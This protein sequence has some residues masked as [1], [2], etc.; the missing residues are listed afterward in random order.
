MSRRTRAGSEPLRCSFCHK[1]EPA[2]GKLISSPNDY[3]RVYICDECIAVCKRILEDDG[4]E[5]EAP[6]S[7][8]FGNASSAEVFHPSVSKLVKAVEKWIAKDSSGTDA[9]AE[10]ETMRRIAAR[11]FGHDS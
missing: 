10:L 9:A 2:V 7:A 8:P 4:V 3:P 11:L 6:P 5:N 1:A